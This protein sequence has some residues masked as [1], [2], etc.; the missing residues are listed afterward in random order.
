MSEKPGSTTPR[1][2]APIVPK[3][4]SNQSNARGVAEQRQ[5]ADARRRLLLGVLLVAAFSLLS[6]I[7]D[8][9]TPLSEVDASFSCDSE[10]IDT[11][12]KKKKKKMFFFFFF[13]F[14]FEEEKRVF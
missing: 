14:L 13:F 6:P 5:H 4:I 7:F 2:I 12:K 11:R 3:T 8:L 9:S 1:P 10:T